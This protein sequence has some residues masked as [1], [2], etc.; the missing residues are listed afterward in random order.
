MNFCWGMGKR[1]R[2]CL[3]W[4]RSVKS[5]VELANCG[6]EDPR[7]GRLGVRER[8]SLGESGGEEEGEETGELVPE[9]VGEVVGEVV[10]EASVIY[11]KGEK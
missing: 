11:N 10:G 6:S 4:P 7:G 9:T 1:Q 8:M 5:K 2:S 3:R